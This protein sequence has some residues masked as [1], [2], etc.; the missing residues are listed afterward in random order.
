MNKI[1]KSGFYLLLSIFL[2]IGLQ[3][4]TDKIQDLVPSVTK[5]I[6]NS[7]SKGFI[8]LAASFLKT[9]G[10]DPYIAVIDNFGTTVFFRRTEPAALH[11]SRTPDNRMAYFSGNHR[12]LYFLNDYLNVTDSLTI[13]GEGN[14]I[15]THGYFVTEDSHVILFGY[16]LRIVDMSSLVSGGEE[17]ATVKD[18]II[19]EFDENKELIFSWNS[20]DHFEIMDANEASP[21]IDFTVSEI[22]Y[23]HANSVFADTD[24]SLLLSCRYMDEITKIDRR[25][26]EIIWRFGGKNNEFTFVND[27]IRFSHQHSI[28]KS[29][30]GNFL[31]FDNGNL[32]QNK[33]SS[34]VE[35]EVDEKNKIATLVKRIYHTPD[36]YISFWG[37]CQ[38]LENE[39]YMAGWGYENPSLTEYNSN[40]L[41]VLELD[42]SSHS[43]SNS[44]FKGEWS[45]NLFSFDLDSIEMVALNNEKIIRKTVKL[46]NNLDKPLALTSFSTLSGAFSIDASFPINLDSFASTLLDIIFITDSISSGYQN[47]VITL[48]SDSEQERIS[49]Q[50]FVEGYKP[51]S[52]APEIEIFPKG[53]WIANDSC[54]TIKF[55]E[56]V[57]LLNGEALTNENLVGLFNFKIID[58]NGINVPYYPVVNSS[59][60]K[61]ILHPATKLVDNQTYFIGVDIIF[62]D[63]NHNQVNA[64]Q[65]LFS[66]GI[67][68]E[69]KIFNL[70]ILSLYPNPSN[71]S[72]NIIFKNPGQYN[73]QIYNSYGSLVFQENN[74]QSTNYV[75]NEGELSKG[76]YFLHVKDRDGG[77]IIK[78]KF[79]L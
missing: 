27:E 10:G 36:L 64:I 67:I 17:F 5:V 78:E 14:T 37:Y 18:L 55:S 1:L 76:I 3:A 35:Y 72:I 39:N 48:N 23:V 6:S 45:Q 33:V 8:Y 4:Q 16:S 24:T 41:P 20:A 26:G 11:F 29:D 15:D 50:I 65:S 46:T 30:N 75:I 52:K 38:F 25:T 71:G 21:Y 61:I 56:P 9:T 58:S 12:K 31:L 7:P 2:N 44:I 68:L 59:K 13:I 53:N 57:R 47:D 66:T 22:D 49:A 79:I 74:I 28:N 73:V 63:Y 19:Q 34:I 32:H 70:N 43:F 60:D 69:N 51:D 42:F 77:K 40:G 62:E 54:V